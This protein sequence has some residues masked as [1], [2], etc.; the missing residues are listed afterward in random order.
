MRLKIR[1][2]GESEKFCKIFLGAKQG[3]RPIGGKFFDVTS[4]VSE[5]CLGWVL[6]TNKKT[7]Y[8]AHQETT[9]QIY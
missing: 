9:R 3:L 7:N 1:C 5:G 4:D 8:I 6:E 2:D